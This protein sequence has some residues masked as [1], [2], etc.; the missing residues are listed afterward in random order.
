MR[1]FWRHLNNANRERFALHMR[2]QNHQETMAAVPSL[3]FMK[4][5]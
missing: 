1:S 3:K 2:T 4:K 5:K